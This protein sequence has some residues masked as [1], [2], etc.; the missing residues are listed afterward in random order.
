MYCKEPC[1]VNALMARDEIELSGEADYEF[2]P[3]TP[4]RRLEKRLDVL[5][6]TKSTQSLERF[7]DK[8]IDMTELNQKIVDGM[9][10]SNQSL[11]EDVGVLIGKMDSLNNNLSEFVT[12]IKTAGEQD[13]ESPSKDAFSN[14]V[15]PLV[16]KVEEITR[17]ARDSN[18][19]IAETLENIDKRLKR[20]QATD[21][22]QKPI[23]N[24]FARRDMIPQQQPIRP[25][26]P[27]QTKPRQI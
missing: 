23:N 14:A 9:V 6:T 3:L 18:A 19:A 11:R 12:L 4:V 1:T 7:V 13:V 24:I 10:K 17:G 27:P 21:R 8:I 5:E 26:A 20:M 2:V 16:D 15:K 22:I 25:T